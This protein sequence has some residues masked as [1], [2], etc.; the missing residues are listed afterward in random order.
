[1]SGFE[2]FER[3]ASYAS[4][5]KTKRKRSTSRARSKNSSTSTAE[6]KPKVQKNSNKSNAT[7]L[8]LKQPDTTTVDASLITRSTSG[9]SRT[10][11]EPKYDSPEKSILNN[12]SCNEDEFN[13]PVGTSSKAQYSPQIDEGD[14]EPFQFT[15]DEMK[16][17]KRPHSINARL[18]NLIQ[19][20]PSN[21]RYV[22]PG[23]FTDKFRNLL[24]A[25]KMDSVKAY[26]TSKND[27]INL[28]ERRIKVISIALTSSEIIAK[29]Q[30]FDDAVE[31][32]IDDG[33]ENFMSLSS[34]I[35]GEIMKIHQKFIVKIEHTQEA[36]QNILWNCVSHLR[37]F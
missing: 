22:K 14:S 12:I 4:P 23:G 3:L 10:N 13:V 5:P 36:E 21:L 2:K 31:N 26:G 16:L 17:E 11:L 7:L 27:Q 8:P 29:F 34:E 20:S 18:L 37:A 28:N 19:S 25:K 32:L 15:P 33:K 35:Y 24:K 6:R 30:F 9:L 1:M